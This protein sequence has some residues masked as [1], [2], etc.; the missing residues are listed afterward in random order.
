MDII[1]IYRTFHLMEAEYTFFSS[2]HG[3]FSKQ[4]NDRHFCTDLPDPQLIHHSMGLMEQW[5]AGTFSGFSLA[6]TSTVSK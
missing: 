2:A 6:Y 3:A 1:D 4:R 5:R